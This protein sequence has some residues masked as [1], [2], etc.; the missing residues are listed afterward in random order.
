MEMEKNMKA[1]QNMKKVSYKTQK[2][3]NA[4][5]MFSKNEEFLANI[6]VTEHIKYKLLFNNKVKMNKKIMNCN[7]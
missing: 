3:T 2:K 7:V 5:K 1:L 4:R 6:N